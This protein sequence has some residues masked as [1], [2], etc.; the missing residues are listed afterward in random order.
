MARAFG[1]CERGWRPTTAPLPLAWLA[2]LIG[3]TGCATPKKP[4]IDPTTAT[5]PERTAV[6]PSASAKPLTPPPSVALAS[7]HESTSVQELG[8]ISSKTTPKT[9]ATWVAC[10]EKLKSKGGDPA[11]EVA[12]VA[13][14]CQLKKQ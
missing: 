8:P 13:N 14:A 6:R 11:R 12:T 7:P 1:A 3:I 10:Y 5:S 2:T 4:A 9:D